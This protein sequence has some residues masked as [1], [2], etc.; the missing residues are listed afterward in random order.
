MQLLQAKTR[1]YWFKMI[2]EAPLVNNLYPPS[3]RGITVLIDFLSE[4]KVY[5]R[6]KDSSG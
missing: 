6:V 5:T 1:Y 3:A 2:S 4:L